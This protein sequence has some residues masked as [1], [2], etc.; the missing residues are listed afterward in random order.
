[1]AFSLKDAAGEAGSIAVVMRGDGGHYL[2]FNSSS[3]TWTYRSFGGLVKSWA[4]MRELS[5]AELDELLQVAGN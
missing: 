4:A 1:L 3:Q 5:A 2:Q